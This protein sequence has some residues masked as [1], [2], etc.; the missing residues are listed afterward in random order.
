MDLN[1][2]IYTR[3]SIRAYTNTPID[4]SLIEEIISAATYAPTAMNSQPWAFAV[5][6]NQ[7]IINDLSTSTKAYMLANLD[8]MPALERYKDMFANPSFNI[9]HGATA[10]VVICSKANVSV[11]PEIDCSMAAQNLMLAARALGLG[12]CWNGFAQIYLSDGH[13]KED[14][15]IPADYTVVAPIGIGH[16]ACSFSRAE[17]NPPE[18]FAWK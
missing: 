15:G 18:I 3:R 11:T 8:K 12:S 9:F 17:K 10:I 4:R 7:S 16:P 6:Q 5:I 13:A 1:E 2:A 14:F